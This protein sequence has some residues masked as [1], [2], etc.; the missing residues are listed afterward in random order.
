MT[1]KGFIVTAALNDDNEPVVVVKPMEDDA[2]STLKDA[3]FSQL[4]LQNRARSPA[5]LIKEERELAKKIFEQR[6]VCET[7]FS[8]TLGCL[9]LQVVAELVINRLRY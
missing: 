2:R 9:G 1:S 7:K 4:S 8:F 3:V 5:D 6:F